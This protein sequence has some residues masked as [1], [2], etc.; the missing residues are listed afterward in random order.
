MMM[1]FDVN[2][3]YM[4]IVMRLRLSMIPGIEIGMVR[5]EAKS[6]LKSC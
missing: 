2:M 1:Y 5:P 4:V 6:Q 3:R